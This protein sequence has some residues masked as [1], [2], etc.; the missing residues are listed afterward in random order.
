MSTAYNDTEC[1]PMKL[2]Q[3]SESSNNC[4]IHPIDRLAG[5]VLVSHVLA[6]HLRLFGIAP[7]VRR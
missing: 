4:K 3:R 2:Y 6:V 7:E 1:R 5:P